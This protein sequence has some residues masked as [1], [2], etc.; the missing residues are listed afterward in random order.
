MNVSNLTRNDEVRVARRGIYGLNSFC[1]LVYNQL[2]QLAVLITIGRRA[3]SDRRRCP[4][5]GDADVLSAELLLKLRRKDREGRV[6][7]LYEPQVLP[8][9][10]I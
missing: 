1:F 6:G 10:R 4:G 9:L 8:G 5:L 3:D 7:H 2:Q